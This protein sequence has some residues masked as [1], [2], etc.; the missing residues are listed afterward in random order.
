MFV[1]TDVDWLIGE[2]GV[3]YRAK[4]IKHEGRETVAAKTLKGIA[5]LYSGKFVSGKS[6]CICACA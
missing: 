5:L 3:V 2:F 4:L 1:Y 6:T